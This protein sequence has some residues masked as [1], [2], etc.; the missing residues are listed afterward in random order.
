M[1]IHTGGQNEK[2]VKDK[3]LCLDL[4]IAIAALLSSPSPLLCSS[5]NFPSEFPACFRRLICSLY[6]NESER[7]KARRVI[8]ERREKEDEKAAAAGGHFLCLAPSRSTRLEQ[9]SHRRAS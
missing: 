7:P 1:S 2:A 8:G 9:T 6:W 4:P 5:R 3:S